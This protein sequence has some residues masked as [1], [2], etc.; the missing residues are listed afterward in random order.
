MLITTSSYF[1][2]A[3]FKRFVKHLIK[4]VKLKNKKILLV[5]DNARYHK[6]KELKQFFLKRKD[7]LELLFLPPYSPD[8]NPIE[9]EWRETRRNV[10]HN[11]YFSSM[12]LQ[13]NSIMEYWKKNKNSKKNDIFSAKS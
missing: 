4:N 1:N 7:K 3:S 6:A 2:T 10:T 12:E 11:K 5:L 8:L 9:I 13:K